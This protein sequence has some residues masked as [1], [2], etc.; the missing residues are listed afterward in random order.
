MILKIKASK[1]S[2]MK[3]IFPLLTAVALLAGC[4]DTNPIVV[5]TFR[6]NP[7]SGVLTG[8]LRASGSPYL[9]T[10][11]LT[12]P[13]DQTLVIEA[14]T[15]LRFEPGV[16]FIVFGR[17][18]ANGSEAAPIT[19]T[20]GSRNPMRGDWDGVWLESADAG[21]SFEYCR[22]LFGA[23]FG[24][25]YDVDT[26]DNDELDSARIEYGCLTLTNSSPRVRRS[27]FIAGGFHGVFCGPGSEP[28]IEN[29]VFFDNAGHGVYVD[30]NADPTIN[31]SIIS[32]NDDYGVFCAMPGQDRR[33]DVDVNYNIVIENFSGEFN[34]QAPLRLGLIARANGNLD[35]CD[36]RFNLRLNPEYIDASKIKNGVS[37]NFHLNP[38]SSAIDA[39]PVDTL[40]DIRDHTRRLDLGVHRYDYRRGEL[41]RLFSEDRLTAAGSPYTLSSNIYLPSGQ[42]LTIDPGVEIR[43]EGRFE[44][45]L[46]GRLLSSGSSTNPVKFTSASLTPVKG[47]WIGLI[48]ENG[49]DPGS[50]LSY[51]EIS[52]ARWGVK[53]VGQDIRIANCTISNS[54][55]VGVFCDNISSPSIEDCRFV[56]NSIAG[57]LCRFNSSPSISGNFITG[58]KGY[59][60][61]AVESSRPKIENNIIVDNETDG[62]RLENLSNAVIVNNVFAN[63]RYFGLF[64]SNNSSPDVRNNIFTRNGSILRGGMGVSAENSSSPIIEYND[65]WGNAITAVSISGDRTLSMLTN[66]ITDPIFVDLNGS[67][68]RLK[69]GSLCI[70]AGDSLSQYNDPDGSR[71]DMGAYGGP[72]AR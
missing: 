9:A 27:W 37:W 20:S 47:D 55:S 28:V 42:N 1:E 13:R 24:R 35:S 71:N 2:L 12:V 64:C 25:H 69:P 4:T 62:V 6:G 54:D 36:Y 53:L 16:P 10:S 33:G 3:R 30:P 61:H 57:I 50:V 59:G 39:G 44:I 23:K 56:G 38:W 65:F 41:R 48:F 7:I 22:F 60:I 19:F 46:K 45:R 72:H 5:D 66:I 70:N 11:A 31:Y 32:E 67:N 17:I 68:Y 14:G 34:Q 26:L 51:T 40:I 8:T 29:S 15:E 58:G 43:V 63:N 52:H 18:N 49:G 21:S